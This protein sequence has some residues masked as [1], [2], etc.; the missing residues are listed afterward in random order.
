M[1]SVAKNFYFFASDPFSFDF[2]QR[3][4]RVEAYEMADKKRSICHS[5]NW[6]HLLVKLPKIKPIR[7]K[8]LTF[9][10]NQL[11]VNYKKTSVS[12]STLFDMEVFLLS[13]GG[14]VSC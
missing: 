12:K 10:Y 13:Q 7:N 3:L 11:P 1:G 8:N 9:F 2:H 5:I 14:G 6:Q 4:Y